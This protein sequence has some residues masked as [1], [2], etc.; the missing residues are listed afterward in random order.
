MRARRALACCRSVEIK[1]YFTSLI[2]RVPISRYFTADA[3]GLKYSSYIPDT[4]EKLRLHAG[5]ES[6]EDVSVAM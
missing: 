1:I 4:Y 3:S 2:V 6:D 5:V